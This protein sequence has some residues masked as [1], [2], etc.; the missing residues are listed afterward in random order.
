VKQHFAGAVVWTCALGTAFAQ[1]PVKIDFIRDVQPLFKEHCVECHGPKQQ[2]NGYRLDRRRDAMRGGT[3]NM[4]GPGNSAASGLYLKL[5]GTR[6][7]AQMPPAGPLSA[8]QIDVI[9]AWIDQG[10]VWPDDASGETASPPPDPGAVRMMELLRNGDR[11]AFR[12]MLREEPG[13]ARRKGPGGSTPLM[14]A[15]LYG[16]A[17]SV[18][19]LLE[20]GADPNARNEAGATGLMW[21]V[22]D[23]EKTRLLLKGGADAKARSDDGRS[24]LL[25]AARRFGSRDVVKLLLDSGASPSEKTHGIRGTATPLSEAA[26]AGD[27]AVLRLLIER[28]A[29]VKGAG[30]V[31]LG[32]ALNAHDPRCADLLLKSADPET[33]KMA[34]LLVAPPLAPGGFGDAR[35]TT[36][37]LDRGADAKARDREGRTA[38]MLAAGA[39]TLPVESVKA[40]IEHGADVNAKDPDDRTALD[41]ARQQGRTPVVDLLV[42]AGAREGRAPTGPVIKPKP[43]GSARAALERSIP[44]LQQTDVSFLRKSGCVSCHN[45]TLTAM[46]VAKARKNG[47]PVDD[48]VA[49]KQLKAIASRIDGWRERGLQNVGIPGDANTISSILIGMAAEDY[50]PDTTTDAWAHF[51]KG[52]QLPD[53]R[54]R[55]LGHR[56]PLGASDF[57]TTA[58]SL[59]AIQ[60][61]APKPRRAEYEKAVRL[62]A[63]WL[64]KARPTTNTDR[65]FQLL[66]LAWAGGNEEPIRKAAHELLAE[67]RPD[68]GWAQLPSLESDAFATGQALVALQET[69]AV[70]ANDPAYKRGVR[71]LLDAQ[72][73]DG[74]WY[75]KS[76]SLPF[77]PYF[78]SGFPHGHDQWISA[79]ATNWA[80]MA[81]MP[82][83]R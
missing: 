70:E 53:G 71:F 16:D 55:S 44:L 14:Y 42:K 3:S 40:L 78:E 77:Q 60:Q 15:V 2:K 19:L 20:S 41:F 26:A 17:E 75:V 8:E 9:K 33:V 61:Y 35:T 47:L 83:A 11:D 13:A 46:S 43:A 57:Q 52:R 82:S 49:R 65:A 18:R 48:Q 69:G 59:R 67:Q 50:K 81:L 38:L 51:L 28:G 39:D 64:R 10:A 76:R 36:T 74:S 21:A 62:A 66:G 5:T 4:I 12:K 45:N 68:G 7:G 6:R 25:I 27:E 29:D 1:D 73:G 63:E 22:D 34:L 31:A 80:A 30:A 23:L 32:A 58:T 37:L 54:W 24:P 56:P 79:A 72:L